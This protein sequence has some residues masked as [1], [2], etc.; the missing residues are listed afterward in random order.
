M[1]KVIDDS[2]NSHQDKI[3]IVDDNKANRDIAFNFLVNANYRVITAPSG[4]EALKI[5][6]V[7]KPDLI[8]LDIM[9]PG[10]SG[11][12]VCKK[13]KANPDTTDIPVIFL[14][15]LNQSDDFVK[16]F[17]YGAVDYMIKP[18]SRNIFLTRVKNQIE[19]VRRNKVI[20]RQNHILKQLNEDKNGLLAITVHDLKN[21]LQVILSASEML[22]RQIDPEENPT[23]Y[24][25]IDSIIFSAKKANNIIQD[26]LEVQ[27]LEEGKI[28]A[29]LSVFDARDI[30]I[31]LV[32]D[33]LYIAHNKHIE[34]IYEESDE[35][36]LMLSDSRKLSRIIENLLSNAIK[37]SHKNTKVILKCNLDTTDFDEKLIHISI[38]DQGPGFLDEDIPKIFSKFSK[39]SARPTADESSTGLGLSIVKK[40]TELLDGVIFFETAPGKGTCFHLKFSF[41]M[42]SE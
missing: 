29:D 15:A 26:L 42:K 1:E 19:L 27:A 21:P 8:L 9:M 4:D 16:G 38:S 36:C 5:L 37:F 30:A 14:T 40:L 39:L 31:T 33:Y 11:F 12:E 6:K 41:C 22:V 23:A 18:F 35:P 32:D 7:D 24:E 3:L 10:I 20:L 13:I 17:E 34:L 2:V 25:M 28:K